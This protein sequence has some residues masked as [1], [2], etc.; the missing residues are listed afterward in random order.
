[1]TV[2]RPLNIHRIVEIEFLIIDGL[3]QT[4]VNQN[5]VL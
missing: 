4:G 3:Y 1:M 5:P 2:G